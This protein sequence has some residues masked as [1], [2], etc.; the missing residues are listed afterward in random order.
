M[1]MRGALMIGRR[2]SA[3][4]ATHLFTLFFILNRCFY[5]FV[6]AAVRTVLCKGIL[7]QFMIISVS[8]R[9]EH[10][11]HLTLRTTEQHRVAYSI[12]FE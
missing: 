11:A 4:S 5:F 3:V 2:A 10:V 1:L 6:I 9:L 8:E 7:F 12:N